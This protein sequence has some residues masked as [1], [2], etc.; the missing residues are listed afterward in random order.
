MTRYWTCALVV[1]ALTAGIGA[2]PAG[3]RRDGMWSNPPAPLDP[4]DYS[5]SLRCRTGPDALRYEFTVVE[6]TKFTRPWAVVLPMRRSRG[7]LYKFACHEGNYGL[8]NILRGARSE[9]RK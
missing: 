9:E 7:P 5:G 8:A 4:A 3:A 1:A 2:Q 6:P